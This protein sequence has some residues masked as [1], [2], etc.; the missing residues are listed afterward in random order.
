LE[1]QTAQRHAFVVVD[2]NLLN[3][4]VLSRYLQRLGLPTPALFDN[5]AAALQWLLARPQRGTRSVP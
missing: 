2:D 1:P 4:K 5:G 3:Q